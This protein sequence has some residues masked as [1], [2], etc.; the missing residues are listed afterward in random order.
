MNMTPLLSAVLLGSVVL[1]PAPAGADQNNG[2]VA[3]TVP[4]SPHCVQATGSRLPQTAT[5]CAVVGR[6]YTG[7][8]LKQTGTTSL[9][10]ALKMLDPAVTVR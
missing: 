6:S 7:E 4:A 10:D 9:G 1:S 2:P 8:D 5:P 3:A